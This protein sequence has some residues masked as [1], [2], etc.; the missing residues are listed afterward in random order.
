MN[1]RPSWTLRFLESHE[2][3]SLTSKEELPDGT[4][5][6]WRD[7][8]RRRSGELGVVGLSEHGFVDA[9]RHLHGNDAQGP[10]RCCLSGH[11]L[12]GLNVTPGALAPADPGSQNHIGTLKPVATPTD[13][14]SGTVS[15]ISNMCYTPDTAVSARSALVRESIEQDRRSPWRHVCILPTPEVFASR[16]PHAAGKA[17][18]S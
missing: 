16:S 13:N 7:A 11:P 15:V 14:C 6:P 5:I 18:R 4:V 2:V 10:H 17:P 8:D 1:T 9:L 3:F 12:A